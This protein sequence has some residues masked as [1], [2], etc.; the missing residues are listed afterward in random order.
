MVLALGTSVGRDGQHLPLVRRPVSV[1]RM[2]QHPC[3]NEGPPC[4][5]CLMLTYV[6]MVYMYSGGWIGISAAALNKL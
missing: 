5:P 1:V 4:D 6:H 3:S 2:L